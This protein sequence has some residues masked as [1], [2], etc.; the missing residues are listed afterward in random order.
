MKEVVWGI[1]GFL[2]LYI[3]FPFLLTRLFGFGVLTRTPSLKHVYFTFDDGPDPEYTPRLL[4]LLREYGVKATFFVVGEKA[5]KHPDLIRLIDKDGHEIGIHNRVHLPNWFLSP[6]RLKRDLDATASYIEGLTGKRPTLYRPPW[7]ILSL[8]DLFFL[9]SYTIT[10]WSFMGWDWGK[11][12]RVDRL[13][14]RLLARIRGGEIIL[15]HDSGR[16][17]GADPTAPARMMTALEETLREIRHRGYLYLPMNKVREDFLSEKRHPVSRWK[18][19][20]ARLTLSIDHLIRRLIGVHPIEGK[21]GFLYARIIRYHGP[22]ISLENGEQIVKGD[23]LLEIHLNNDILFKVGIQSQNTMRWMVQL[24]RALEDFLPVVA[25]ILAK[26]PKYKEIKGLY[27][28]SLVNRGIKPFGFEVFDLSD[29]WFTF[30]TRSYLRLFMFL[31]HPHGRERLATKTDLLIP[32][33]IVM[34][35][36]VLLERYGPQEAPSPVSHQTSAS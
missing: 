24:I 8:A 28:I 25:K 2:F 26:Q 1:V 18:R 6:F 29:G 33:V 21:D 15:L 17:A 35:R 22:T 16:T 4:Q 23:R 19:G 10:I 31:I 5:M 27:G 30:L 20:I 36:A 34:S 32:K 11:R 14:R 3:G 9:R 13:K 7:G 12:T